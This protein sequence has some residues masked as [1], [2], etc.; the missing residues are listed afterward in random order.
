FSRTYIAPA[1]S[2]AA[3]VDPRLIQAVKDKDADSVRALLKQRVDVN[4]TQGD[5]ATALHWAAHRDDLAIA[6]LL[7]RAG[8]RA[9]AADDLGAT[10]LHVACT[11]RSGSMVEH[12][13]KADAN[14][15]A[16]LLSGETAPMTC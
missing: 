16:T 11:N 10:P 13:L 5:G 4:A 15:N 8:A 12:L 7:L 3:G 1:M 6:D 14:A 9:N 2:A